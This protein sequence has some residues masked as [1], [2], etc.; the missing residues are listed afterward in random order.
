MA[1]LNALARPRGKRLGTC[2]RP[3]T[4]SRTRTCRSRRRCPAAIATIATLHGLAP[5]DP[6]AARVLELGCG[7]RR[8]TSPGVAAADP[9]RAGGRGRPRGRRRSR[10]RARTPPRRGLDNARFDVADVLALTDGPARR[11]RLRDRPRPLRVGGGSRARGGARRVPQPPRARRHRLPLLH[12][13][14]GRAPAAR[15]CATMAPVAR[16]RARRTPRERAER[17][18]GLFTLLDRFGESGGPDVLRGRPGRGGARARDGARADARPR[19]ARPD[20]RARVVRGLRGG[21]GAP[22]ARLRRRRV[23]REPAASRRGRDAVEAFVADA[24]GDD[25]IAREQYFDLLVLRRFRHSLLCH[26]DARAR[27]ARRPRRRSSGCSWR[28]TATGADLRRAAARRARRRRAAAAVA[29]ASC[30]SALGVPAAELAEHA[31]RGVRRR[32]RRVPRRP[33]ARGRRPPASARARA[34]SRAARRGR[35]RSSRRC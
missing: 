31:R 9:G 24:A 5:P 19:P 30:A 20:L 15:C 27:A 12:R 33:A 1:T 16:A 35:A 8:D 7:A 29:F 10:P 4:R 2:R 22:R 28:R 21:G 34:R 14:S 13:A 3:T 25:R 26:A 11:V 23:A 18:R 6:R 17:A 32:R